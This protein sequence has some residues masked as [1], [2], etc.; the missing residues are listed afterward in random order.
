MEAIA[1]DSDY[2]QSYQEELHRTQLAELREHLDNEH[3]RQ[4]E[5]TETLMGSMAA[6]KN[7]ST[8]SVLI[9]KAKF[10]LKD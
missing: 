5:K 2:R 1:M 9:N 7:V 3:R 8:A 4:T 10:S 6:Q